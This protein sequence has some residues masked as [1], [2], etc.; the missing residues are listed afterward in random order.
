MGSVIAAV[1]YVAGK[2]AVDDLPVLLTHGL[3]NVALSSVLLVGSLRSDV[4]REFAHLVQRR[5]PAFII[6]GF[7]EVVLASV[8]NIA[9]IWALSL[10]PVSLVSA[11]IASRSLFVVL[12]STI[13]AMRF[14]GFLGEDI[15]GGTVIIKVVATTLIV[16]GVIG[17]TLGR[18]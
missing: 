11:L 18:T 13:A 7:N 12:Y 8:S 5:S 3:R 16:A 9:I 17:I 6:V 1:A 15:S 10:G 14:R 4:V 2:L